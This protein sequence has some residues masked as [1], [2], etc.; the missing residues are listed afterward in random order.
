MLLFADV[1][2]SAINKPTANKD[3][4]T[5]VV[6]VPVWNHVEEYLGKFNSIGLLK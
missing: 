6:Q 2:P 3:N 4:T 5:I 1:G